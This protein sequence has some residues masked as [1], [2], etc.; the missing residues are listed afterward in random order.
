MPEP[1][2]RLAALFARGAKANI[3]ARGTKRV[4][5]E[6]QT[7]NRK[8]GRFTS[9]HMTLVSV[10]PSREYFTRQGIH[11]WNSGK[12]I[13]INSITKRISTDHGRL[14]LKIQEA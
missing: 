14:K 13:L 10:D 2:Y 6:T 1:I 11:I 7:F 4:N 8:V 12:D 3:S 9:K 5:K